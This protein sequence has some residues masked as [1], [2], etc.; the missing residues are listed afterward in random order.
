MTRPTWPRLSR[1]DVERLGR[2][3]RRQG[4]ERGAGEVWGRLRLAVGGDVPG[5]SNGAEE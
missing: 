4:G 5:R 1:R 3:V 2:R